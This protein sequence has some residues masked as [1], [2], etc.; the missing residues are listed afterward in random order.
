MPEKDIEP[1]FSSQ[2]MA[3]V[4]LGGALNKVGYHFTTVTPLT[5]AR[6]NARPSNLCAKDLAGVFGWSRPF[7]AGLLPSPMVSLMQEA[8]V[9]DGV[10][11]GWRSTVRVSSIGQQLFFHSAYP[12]LSP[13]SV[14]FG[15]DT[16]RFASAIGAHLAGNQKPIA[17]AVDIGC[18][19]GPGGIVIAKAEPDA[20]VLMVDINEQALRFSRINAALNAVPNAEVH[21]S[22]ILTG[23]D[24]WFD[25]IVSNPPYLVDHAA[26]A[27]RHGGGHLGEGLSVA[28]LKAAVA[29]L[30]RGGTLL[31]YTGS[32]IV[33]G[34]DG[35]R[36]AAET[37]LAGTA[38]RWSYV[39]VDPDVFGEELEAGTYAQADRIAALVLTV[40]RED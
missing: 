34:I 26:R 8:G 1:S 6:V 22:D 13:N 35:F 23:T 21:G 38:H 20:Q 12:T 9:L 19:A 16:Y 30:S 10:E 15:P 39:E 7:E 37:F 3:L 40:T 18:G 11:G 27:Y 31:L 33:D 5:H 24:G 14:F 25:L 17:R 36:N 4:E 32:A 2:D 28:I 29:R